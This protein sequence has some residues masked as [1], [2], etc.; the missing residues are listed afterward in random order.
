MPEFT[1]EDIREA[2]DKRFGPTILKIKGGSV[3]LQNFMR[4]PKETRK[5]LADLDAEDVDDAEEKFDQIIRLAAKTEAQASRLISALDL[6]DKAAVIE[7]W[8][9]GTQLGEARPSPI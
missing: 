5:A 7:M 2:A 6:A 9:K 4:L 8:T 1:L 3:E